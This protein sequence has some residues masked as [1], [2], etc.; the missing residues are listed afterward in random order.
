MYVGSWWLILIMWNIFHLDAPAN[1]GDEPGLWLLELEPEPIK[2]EEDSGW[3]KGWQSFS[4]EV[5]LSN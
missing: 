1:E 5:S 3:R 4:V 2:L